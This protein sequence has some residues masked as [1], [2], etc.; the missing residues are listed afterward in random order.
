ML[1]AEDTSYAL[2]DDGSKQQVFTYPVRWGLPVT[3]VTSH[4]RMYCTRVPSLHKTESGT[5]TIQMGQTEG[6]IP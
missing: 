5:A 4:R 1:S 3:P 2:V 6:G